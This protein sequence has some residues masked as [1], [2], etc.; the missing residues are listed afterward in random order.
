MK[1]I[2]LTGAAL[3][4]ALLAGQANAAWDA[5]YLGANGQPL[6][7]NMV[8]DGVLTES[9]MAGASAPTPLIE[10]AFL[11]DCVGGA[12][13]KYASG[14]SNFA[15]VC[16]RDTVKLPT[17]STKYILLQK[18]DGGG[19]ITGIVA[20]LPGG[21]ATL[22][23]NA[24]L[25][26]VS[27]GAL[28]APFTLCTGGAL[29]TSAQATS[30]NFADVDP[31]KFSFP[32][33]NADNIAHP[34]YCSLAS[35]PVAAQ[36]FGVQVNL[37]LRNA[38]QKAMID[39][40]VMPNLAT[41]IPCTVGDERENCMPNLTSAQ[42]STLLSAANTTGRITDW[43]QLRWG[44]GAATQNVF[45]SQAVIDRPLNRD[46][47]I[48]NR[49]P[50]SGTLAIQ[51]LKHENYPCFSGSEP[52][53]AERTPAG[54]LIPVGTENTVALPGTVFTNGARRVIHSNSSQGDVD[55]CLEAL[56]NGADLGSFN[57][58][59]TS[60]LGVAGTVHTAGAD[61]FRWALGT[62]SVDR[63]LSGFV[64]DSTAAFPGVAC[65]TGSYA[66]AFR[67]IKIDNAA[68]TL[69]NVVTGRYR[70]WAELV[71]IGPVSGALA[72]DIIANMSNPAEI[73]G[74]NPK[75]SW[76]T[77]GL[78]GYAGNPLAPPVGNAGL[79][80]LRPINPYTHAAEG[81]PSTI[82]HCRVTTV[83][84]ATS[85]V[86]RPMPTFYPDVL[87]ETPNLSAGISQ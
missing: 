23:T 3:S 64:C 8:T 29:A 76:G 83:P 74:I 33:N 68:P 48:C 56:N 79:D 70:Y 82:D 86:P 16:E 51:Q 71:N 53:L 21:T 26:T 12:A 45:D 2:L 44:T 30:A 81:G 40:G 46:I 17:V 24:S 14:T 35:T 32:N 62:S 73:S 36:I 57:A 38:M 15:W 20:A 60:K 28:A 59:S 65:P 19:S 5:I 4:V 1:K 39:A 37:K 47:H 52:A 7:T 25:G 58:Y 55:N 85:T 69:E 31:C 54:V 13:Y 50:G 27:C 43:R 61:K 77:S 72:A 6:I 78:L 66:K 42:V 18:R 22:F 49:Q 75:F 87:R 10:K 11:N 67:Y 9:K 80:L 34:E 84:P 41:A 63:N